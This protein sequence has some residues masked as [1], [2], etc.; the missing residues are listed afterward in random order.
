MSTAAIAKRNGLT[1]GYAIFWHLWPQQAVVDRELRHVGFEVEL[2]ASHQSP[3]SRLSRVSSRSRRV[4]GHCSA[5]RRRHA[6]DL[7]KAPAATYDPHFASVICSPQ[8]G[9]RTCVSVSILVSDARQDDRA[10]AS[11]T[12][13][14][15]R[16]REHLAEL[17]IEELSCPN[18]GTDRLRSAKSP[19]DR[20]SSRTN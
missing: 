15:S 3:R 16:I 17:G 13:A 5:D 8:A 18:S 19:A 10:K 9:N 1:N 4:A 20:L 14:L 12:L 7:A 2:I 6:G 11:E